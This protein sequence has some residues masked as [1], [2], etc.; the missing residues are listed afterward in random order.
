M[1]NQGKKSEW[2]QILPH[3]IRCWKI[4]QVK[5]LGGDLILIKNSIF[6]QSSPQW[7]MEIKQII[8]TC[9]FIFTFN[10]HFMLSLLD[11]E[12]QENEEE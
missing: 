12:C 8:S 6:S 10:E 5:C 7:D 4:E 9:T 11:D 3:G 2:H 1:A